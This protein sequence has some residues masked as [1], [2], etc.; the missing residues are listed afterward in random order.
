MTIYDYARLTEN[1]KEILLQEQALFLEQYKE[2]ENEIQV[3]FLNGFFV[4]VTLKNE[5][6]IYNLPYRRGHKINKRILHEAQKRN[7]FDLAA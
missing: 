5:K 6:V 4:E 7:A 2:D 3:Y 1:E